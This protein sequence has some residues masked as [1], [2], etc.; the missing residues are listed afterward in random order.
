MGGRYKL[1][2]VLQDLA[3]G[4]VAIQ[5]S[6]ATGS[7]AS[8]AV[9]GITKT[10]DFNSC[11]HTDITWEPW[12]QV[13]LGNFYNI[14]YIKVYG[15]NCCS[16]RINGAVVRL[17][18]TWN[19]DDLKNYTQCGQ[20][21]Y[22]YGRPIWF[23]CEAEKVGRYLSV[24]LVGKTGSLQL[25]EVE[26]YGSRQV[27]KVEVR[28]VDGESQFDGRVELNYVNLWGT[29]CFDEFDMQ[30]ATV[31][32]KML[33]SISAI[34]FSSSGGGQNSQPIWLDDLSCKGNETTILECL[35][36]GFGNSNCLHTKDVSVSCV[37]PDPVRLVNGRVEIFHN[38]KWG[39]ICD[40]DWDYRDATV[41]C[42]QLGFKYADRAFN[43]KN[44]PDVTGNIWLDNVKCKGTEQSLV[45]C[46][47]NG[48][49]NHTCGHSE[50]V[51]VSCVNN[52]DTGTIRLTGGAT[53]NEGRVELQYQGEWSAVC[54]DEWDILDADVVC[55]QLGFDKGAQ[56]ATINS[57]FSSGPMQII[58]NDVQCN[59]F[60]DHLLT[61]NHTNVL[62]DHTCGDSK[63]AGVICLPNKRPKN[64]H[65]Q[66]FDPRT[67]T[68]GGT[69]GIVQ[70]F[71]YGKYGTLCNKGWKFDDALR[72]CKA[73]GFLGV[74]NHAA[75]L[76]EGTGDILFARLFGYT[77][78]LIS[79]LSVCD[80]SQD[81]TVVCREE[82]HKLRLVNGKA[83]SQGRVEIN[84]NGTWGTICD[85]N[86]SIEDA[87]VVCKQLGYPSGALVAL[88]GATWGRGEGDIILD[89]VKCT[90]DETALT[91]CVHNGYGEH[92]CN[93][94]EDAG[95]R[96][97]DGYSPARGHI[98]LFDPQANTTG[99]KQGIVQ[100][101]YDGVY[102]GTI[103][104][105]YWDF[106]DAL[107][108]C[109]SLGFL[110]VEN[111]A[112]K[113]GKGT[114]DIIW[115]E[116]NCMGTESDVHYCS[117]SGR[118]NNPCDHSQD[119][120][121]VCSE[122][123]REV[124]LVNGRTEAQG[125][126][127][128]K[129]SGEWGTVCD[130]NWS[131]ADANVVCK[132]LGYANGALIALGGATWGR[133]EGDII[134]DD[135]NC[136]GDESALS[137]CQHNGYGE[138]NCVHNQDAGVRCDDGLPLVDV[139]LVNGRAANEG[140][141]EL[142]IVE[143]WST[144]TDLRNGLAEANVLCRMLG[145]PRAA[146]S[147][148]NAAFGEGTGPILLH[149]LHCSGTEDTIDDCRYF[150]DTSTDH[151]RDVGIVCFLENEL[152]VPVRLADGASPS[153]GRVELYYNGTWGMVCSFDWSL[154]AA[155]VIC[156]SLG[157][158][159][160]LNVRRKGYNVP[161]LLSIGGCRGDESA[162][163]EC[164]GS[165][166]N[167]KYGE[168]AG[169]QCRE[170]Q[171]GDVRLLPY[172][173]GREGVVQIYHDGAVGTICDDG[174]DLADANVVCNQLGYPGADA[175]GISGIIFNAI[176]D[177]DIIWMHNVECVGNET[178]LSQC[179]FPGWGTNNCVHD[180]DVVVKC[181]PKPVPTPH[182]YF[183]RGG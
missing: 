17:S 8:R 75:K 76:G 39:T 74:E 32:C 179:K 124:R 22:Y 42:R 153:E 10:I 112:A 49:G 86:W 132:Q 60:E 95:V 59:G 158:N 147:A 142:R 43:G 25:C 131:I 101:F 79:A 11:S 52:S 119:V 177:S 123:A 13:D 85:D 180:Q 170:W 5:S 159:G 44:I 111:H 50:D 70:V 167:C 14:T 182:Q 118:N 133:G 157:Y 138:H 78:R 129:H 26:V 29:V 35:H 134:L 61:C 24:Q 163:E 28:L 103:C 1:I 110:G 34:G 27:D 136:R 16:Y 65:L 146:I 143:D 148:A 93:H 139:R 104:N 46:T 71:S 174:W 58:L 149:D 67:N 160:A 141:V 82:P 169:V 113:L 96:C 20:V 130:D 164:D 100:V 56:T 128:I 68:T 30:D 45:Q 66:L 114:G 107:V 97:D 3:L 178:S 125:R 4:K 9:D 47:S 121:V 108:A 92:N 151:Y 168:A 117:H 161:T 171:E 84:H 87:N 7:P 48:W 36:A 69:Q 77:R 145:F 64:F 53:E 62:T 176:P 21:S 172:Q 54:C 98:Q 116:V 88:G 31:I 19:P 127:E 154:N 173:R 33:G 89:D 181:M 152:P 40:D 81:V 144:I 140:R 135:V 162:I 37:K 120:A 175:E 72:V 90:G 99:G 83:E 80:H 91:A 109:K 122:E 51:V 105:K 150:T 23:N 115:D 38:D 55:K 106:A 18:K 156:N 166:T 2:N 41:V 137:V 155:H 102:D 6:T 183:I 165:Y 63:H 126:V 57:R 12:W 73:L 15:H 94:N